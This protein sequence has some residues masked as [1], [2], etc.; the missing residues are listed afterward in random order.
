MPVI[1]EKAEG[2]ADVKKL[3]AILLLEVDFNAGHKIIFN[4]RLIPTLE[5][6]NTIP[7]E[8]IGG[9][10]SQAATHLAL[11]KKL[12][13]DIANVQKLP[14][15]TIYADATNCYNRVAYPLCKYLYSVL[16]IR[17]VISSSFI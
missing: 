9:R 7:G 1:L 17:A 15:I 2:I 13:L 4:N 5:A 6:T 10:R 11:D 12:I 3:R 16:Q 14:I 8:V